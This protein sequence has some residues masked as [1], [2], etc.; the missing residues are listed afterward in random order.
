MRAQTFAIIISF[1]ILL[2]V[3][4][5]I[6]RQKM[7]FKYS[8]LWLGACIAVAFLALNEKLIEKISKIAGFELPSNFIF[9][10]L[11][12]FFVFLSLLLT[13]YIN[14]Q[15]SRTETLSQAVGALEYKIKKIEKKLPDED[16][17]SS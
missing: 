1:L 2:F 9:F 10:L 16:K 11:L 12:S 8:A 13:I 6:R 5:S 4:D 15:N 7:T 14:E 3:I 17:K